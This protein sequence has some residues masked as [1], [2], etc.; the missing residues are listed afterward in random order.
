MYFDYKDFIISR[1]KISNKI[2]K[3]SQSFDV[4]NTLKNTLKM[5]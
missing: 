1:S 3:I 4:R 2:T 5:R